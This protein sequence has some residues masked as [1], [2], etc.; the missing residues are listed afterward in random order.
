MWLDGVKDGVVTEPEKCKFDPRTTIGKVQFG[1][2]QVEITPKIASVVKKIWD[3]PSIDG[4]QLWYGLPIGAPF[5]FLANTT[6]NGTRVGLPFFIADTWTR[7]FLKRDPVFDISSIGRKELKDLFFQSQTEYDDLLNNAEPDLSRLRRAGGKLLV[8]HGAADQ[9]IFPQGTTK[10]RQSVERA[11]GGGA[12]VDKYFRYFIASGVDHCGLG[13]TVGAIPS[14][15]F[16]ALI[17]WVEK[18]VAP[19]TLQGQIPPQA[20]EQFM[21]K[22]CRYPLVRK[23]RG[24]G[25]ASSLESFDCV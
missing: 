22:I 19:E 8:W 21:R 23:Y 25:D 20:P 15:I 6:V 2:K 14:N 10:Y 11:M 17:A 4:R 3:G 18:G 9:I 5:D 24:H 12:K 1:G 13:T 7:Y 16:E